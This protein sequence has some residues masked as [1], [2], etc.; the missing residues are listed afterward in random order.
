MSKKPKPFQPSPHEPNM[1]VY[2]SRI[3]EWLTLTISLCL[4][5]NDEKPTLSRRQELADSIL[6]RTFGN[7]PRSSNPSLLV[8]T[9]S[10]GKLLVE[11]TLSWAYTYL[12]NTTLP[13][14]IRFSV[15]TPPHTD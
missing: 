2:S 3:V 13:D 14:L 12:K 7:R 15:P 11:S 4:H 9:I 6:D 5:L 10:D 1:Q 8:T